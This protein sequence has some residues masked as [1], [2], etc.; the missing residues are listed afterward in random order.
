MNEIDYLRAR[1]EALEAENIRLTNE[2]E[3]LS[4]RNEV[5]SNDLAYLFI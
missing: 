2:I 3:I 1:V 4:A 5:L